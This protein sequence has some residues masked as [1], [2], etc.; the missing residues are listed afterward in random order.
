[1][2]AEVTVIQLKT[3]DVT[4]VNV[5]TDTTV[6]SSASATINTATLNFSETNP[7]NIGRTAS[8]GTAVTASRSDH[9]HSAADLLL[10]GGQY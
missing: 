9:V 10:D 4:D 6:I 5:V 7:A 1:M 8:A 2:A 3:S